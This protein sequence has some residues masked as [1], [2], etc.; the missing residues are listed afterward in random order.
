MIGCDLVRDLEMY[1]IPED[2]FSELDK[3]Y[4]IIKV[5]PED[6]DNENIKP[7]VIDT[8]PSSTVPLLLVT[9]KSFLSVPIILSYPTLEK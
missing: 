5:N 8:T 4:G 3:K 2:Y 1:K 6:L 7:K 9:I